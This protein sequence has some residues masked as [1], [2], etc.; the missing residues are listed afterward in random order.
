MAEKSF[1]EIECNTH[2][3]T[4][5]HDEILEGDLANGTPVLVFEEGSNKDFGNIAIGLEEN[6]ALWNNLFSNKIPR[7]YGLVCGKNRVLFRKFGSNQE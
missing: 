6:D 7:G 4:E 5:Y 3:E 2:Y 1:R